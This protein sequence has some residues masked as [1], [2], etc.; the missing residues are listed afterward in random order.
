MFKIIENG[1]F[2]NEWIDRVEPIEGEDKI[3]DKLE[4]Q[5][6]AVLLKLG[7]HKVRRS[8]RL[9]SKGEERM[10]IKKPH[11]EIDLLFV[12]NGKLW[13]VDCK[14]LLAKK[15][16]VLNFYKEIQIYPGQA[17]ILWDRI[18]VIVKK[19]LHSIKS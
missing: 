19:V 17:R 4:F 3:G 6:A 14:I 5:T 11:S 2:K 7:V 8:T 1:D 18:K 13:T 12:W 16:S 15:I 9:K 10:S